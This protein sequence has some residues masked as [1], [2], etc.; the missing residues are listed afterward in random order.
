VPSTGIITKRHLTAFTTLPQLLR[1]MF[2]LVVAGSL[3]VY[4]S[5]VC[6]LSVVRCIS[7]T[8]QDRPTVTV[9]HNVDVGIADSVAASDLPTDALLGILFLVSNQLSF[10]Y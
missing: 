4:S 6:C 1:S 10:I 8:K 9:E 2:S 7:K 3:S 5:S